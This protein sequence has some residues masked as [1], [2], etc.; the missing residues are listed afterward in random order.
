MIRASA[1]SRMYKRDV[2]EIKLDM[3]SEYRAVALMLKV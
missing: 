3:Y 2:Y 1:L